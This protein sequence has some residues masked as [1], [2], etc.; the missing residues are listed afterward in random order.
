MM[1]LRRQAMVRAMTFVQAK[2]S[3]LTMTLREAVAQDY[4]ICARTPVHLV[5]EVGIFTEALARRS[6]KPIA[7]DIAKAMADQ[8]TQGLLKVF[9]LNTQVKFGN[10]MQ[11]P[12]SIQRRALSLPLVLLSCMA[13][14]NVVKTFGQT[15][16]HGTRPPLFAASSAAQHPSSSA[17]FT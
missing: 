12:F 15:L 10:S 7:F 6:G 9:H 1:T 4:A 13:A 3:G 8:Q 17:C 14:D 2:L 5:L 11:Q 16:L